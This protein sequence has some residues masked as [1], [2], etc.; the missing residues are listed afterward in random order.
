MRTELQSLNQSCIAP[1]D[2]QNT[3]RFLW[4][5]RPPEGE[6]TWPRTLP[7]T[8]EVLDGFVASRRAG[9]SE[10]F[11]KDGASKDSLIPSLISAEFT[12]RLE[13]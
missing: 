8:W 12:G 3:A 1:T 6:N 9:Y 10:T 2:L 4:R 11:L 5:L 13:T 7:R